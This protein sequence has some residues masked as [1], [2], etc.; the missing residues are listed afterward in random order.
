MADSYDLQAQI[1]SLKAKIKQDLDTTSPVTP[2]ATTQLTSS[3]M[4]STSTS[5][6][7]APNI[8]L[9]SSCSSPPPAAKEPFGSGK[10]PTGG[11]GPAFYAEQYK[12]HGNDAFKKGQY[13]QAIE[14]FTQGLSFE[15]THA[16]L[17]SNRSACYCHL[18]Q[19]DKALEDA[20][21]CIRFRPEWP[22]GHIRRAAALHGYGYLEK[23]LEAYHTAY[24]D[25][26]DNHDYVLTVEAIK[27]ELVRREKSEA[28]SELRE[29]AKVCSALI[30]ALTQGLGRGLYLCWPQLVHTTGGVP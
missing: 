30:V 20:N 1:D 23:A 22:K 8:V 17:Y 11:P 28:N 5:C 26:P 24:K 15:A 19:W 10:H 14:L 12:N 18:R 9:T 25:D 3:S 2:A 13:K 7:S 27:K 21:S 6:D 16:V 4:S 29:K